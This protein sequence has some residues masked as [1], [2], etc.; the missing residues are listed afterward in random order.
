MR[1][2]RV[3]LGVRRL[4]GAIEHVIG[5][6]MHEQNAGLARLL[7]QH[8]DGG[9]VDRRRKFLFVLRFVDRG[10]GGRVHHDVGP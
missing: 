5:R 8:A 9:A 2:R 7:R 1:M 4:L 3:L 6:I 10:I